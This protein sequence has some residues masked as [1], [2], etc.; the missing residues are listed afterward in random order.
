MYG[1]YRKT[2]QEC[3]DKLHDLI[4]FA[5]D[6]L[7]MD[8]PQDKEDNAMEVD[9]MNYV[10]FL[11][12]NHNLIL[13]GAPGTGKTYLAKKI[14]ES[15]GAEWKMVQFHQ[16]YDYT[17][18]VEGLRPKNDDGK[19]VFERRDGIFKI[20]CEKALKAKAVNSIDNF[21]ESFDKLTD[22]LAENEFLDVPLLSGKGAFRIAL[23][24]NEDGFVTLIPKED[25]KYEKDSTRFYNKAQCYN[26]YRELPGTPKKGFD[27]YRKAIVKE[28]KKS[29]GLKDYAAGN[30]ENNDTS[31]KPFVF[32]IDEINR[33]EMS[34]I[35]GELFFS[36]DPGYRGKDGAIL[37]QYAN[38]QDEANEFDRALNATEYGHFFVPENVYIIGTMNDIDRS[39]ESMDFAMRRRFAFEEITAEQSRKNMFGDGKSWK[40]GEKNADG[41]DETIDVSAHLQAII[42]RMDNLNKAILDEE[43]HLGK[44]YQIGGAYFLKFANYFKGSNDDEAFEKLWDYHIKGVVREYLRGIDD[45]SGILLKNLEDAYNLKASEQK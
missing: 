7:E 1:K 35:F 12:N 3:S 21:E 41:S 36:I 27:N 6:K 42:D 31:T 11:K 25:G 44:D 24:S 39:V 2:L 16:S 29:F 5:K 8:G 45:A 23:N 13:H 22:Y 34:K 33:G 10:D 30:T 43:F 40:T 17:D 18:F 32:I 20:F 9:Y 26:V 14:A 28:M 37:T 15:M 38:L 19:V 4:K